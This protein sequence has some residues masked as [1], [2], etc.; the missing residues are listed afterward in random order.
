MFNQIYIGKFFDI[1]FFDDDC[2]IFNLGCMNITSIYI[3]FSK[4][5]TKKISKRFLIMIIIYYL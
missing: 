2:E 5:D 3:S 4:M 1:F